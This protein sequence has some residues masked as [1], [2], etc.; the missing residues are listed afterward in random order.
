M[1]RNDRQPRSGEHRERGSLYQ[2]VTDRIIAELEAG[3]VPWAH[4]LLGPPRRAATLRSAPGP[5]LRC[6]PPGAARLRRRA[7]PVAFRRPPR[8]RERRA[9][10]CERRASA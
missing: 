3:R 4:S 5:P 6:G 7:Y 10:F 9:R 1:S 2:E 8:F